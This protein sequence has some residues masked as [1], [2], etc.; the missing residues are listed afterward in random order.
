VFGFTQDY[1]TLAI[2][3][4]LKVGSVSDVRQPSAEAGSPYACVI[5]LRVKMNY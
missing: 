2:L 5:F 3:F 1:E 4:K